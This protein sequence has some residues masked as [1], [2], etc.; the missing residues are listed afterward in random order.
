M[1]ALVDERT[2]QMCTSAVLALVDERTMPWEAAQKI[3]K[4]KETKKTQGKIKKTRPPI[5]KTKENQCF[6]WFS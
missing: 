3:K 6:P 5:K 1:L 4:T 2:M